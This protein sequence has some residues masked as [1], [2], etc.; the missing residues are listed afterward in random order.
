M[1]INAFRNVSH[2]GQSLLSDQMEVNLK[3]YFDWCMLGIGGFTNVHIPTSGAFGGD[4]ARLRPVQDPNYTNGK[5][6]EAARKDWVWET[7]VYYDH[8]P[9]D[10]SGVHV[11][12]VFQPSTGVGTYAHHINY[13]LGRVVFDTAISTSA[14]VKCEYS[15]RYL[16]ISTTDATWWRNL[17]FDSL[18]VDHPHFLQTGSGNWAIL[19]QN[20]IQLPHIVIEAIP[21]A[22]RYGFELGNLVQVV[23]QDVLFHVITEHISDRKKIHD[24]ITYQTE[25]RLNTFDRDEA[26]SS[27][28]YPLTWQGD[29]SDDAM[30]WPDLIREYY[31]KQFRISRITSMGYDAIPPMY[32]NII[33]MSVEV[34]I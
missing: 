17:Q 1:A 21:Q 30:M 10:I 26:M 12:G 11:N 6:W 13:P 22:S 8:Q 5:V 33:R 28:V 29:R 20:R 23:T 2:L 19:S 24:I 25:A 9:I 27:G 4:F 15:Y 34:D 31:W 32:Y 14:T 18:R 3:A 16:Q 7:G